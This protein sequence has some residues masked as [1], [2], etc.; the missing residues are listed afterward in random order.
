MLRKVQRHGANAFLIT[1]LS[2]ERDEVLHTD[3]SCIATYRVKGV[4]G[5]G[6]NP[7]LQLHQDGFIRL[8]TGS[9]GERPTGTFELTDKFYQYLHGDVMA[10]SVAA[11]SDQEA[12]RGENTHSQ[13]SAIASPVTYSFA[14]DNTE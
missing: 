9:L 4:K 5:T 6:E 12:V 7:A 3:G 8:R 11:R 13:V 2:E 10:R 1:Q 14:A